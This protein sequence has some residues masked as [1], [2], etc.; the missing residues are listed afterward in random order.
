MN[1]TSEVALTL[2]EWYFDLS[3]S[4]RR[5]KQGVCEPISLTEMKAWVEITGTIVTLDEFSILRA[6]DKAYC[7]EMNKELSDYHERQKEAMKKK[8]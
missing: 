1:V 4:I 3:S 6:M 7:S 2:W 8:T 5:V